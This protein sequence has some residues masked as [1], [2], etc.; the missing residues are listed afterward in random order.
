MADTGTRKPPSAAEAFERTVSAQERRKL[1]AARSGARIWSG[2]GTSGLVGW[3]IGVPTLLGAFLGTWLDKHHAGRHSWTLALLFAGLSLG[4][5][6][7]WHW[8]AREQQE[9]HKEE[10]D[11]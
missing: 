11:K 8:V 9:I 7:A 10:E 3:S 6:N 5:A 2:L 4:C 1:R